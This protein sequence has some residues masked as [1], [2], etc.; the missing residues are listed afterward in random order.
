MVTIITVVF[1]GEKTIKDTIESVCR[2]TVLPGEYLII[3]GGSTDGTPA[4]VAPYLKSYPFIKFISEPDQGIY[5]AMNKGIRQASGDLIG[6]INAD[7]WYENDAIEK[8]SRAYAHHGTGVYYG[9]L[10]YH[11]N[12]MEY[13]LERSSHNFPAERMIPHPA[14]FVSRDI[15]DKHGFFNLKYRYSADLDFVIR[16]FKANA[17]FFPMDD[18]IANF[19][20]GGASYTLRSALE[21]LAIRRKYDLLSSRQYWRSVAIHQLKFLFR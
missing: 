11:L 1:N 4:I 21:A 10:R 16:L 20:I 3:D 15:Y 18:V 12:N 17:P 7:D 6:M 19:R 14:T 2:Q 8:M 13:Y 9:I 5:D